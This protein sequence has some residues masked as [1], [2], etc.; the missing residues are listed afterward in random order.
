MICERNL[1]RKILI[2][3]GNFC[4]KGAQAMLFITVD[5]LRKRYPNIDIL[6]QTCEDLNLANFRFES[7]RMI[8][9]T[10]E[11]VCGGWKTPFIVVTRFFK[12]VLKYFMGRKEDLF[13]SFIEIKKIK[14]IDC[15]IDISG[16]AIG[17]KWSYNQNLEYIKRLNMAKKLEIPFFFMPQSIGQLG[18]SN[19][20]DKKKSKMKHNMSKA[21]NYASVIYA[22][23]SFSK[24]NLEKIGVVHNVVQM[25]DMVLL[26]KSVNWENIFVNVPDVNL[27]ILKTDNNIAIVPNTQIVN[28]YGIETALGMYTNVMNYLVELNYSVYIMSHS[29]E[30]LEVCKELYTKN[31]NSSIYLIENILDCRE[32]EAFISQFDLLVASRYHAL[33]HA[34]KEE[35]P[36]IAISWDEKYKEMMSWLGQEDCVFDMDKLGDIDNSIKSRIKDVLEN[37]IGRKKEI[38]K[39]LEIIQRENCFGFLDDLQF[40]ER[41]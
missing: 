34:L 13:S 15:I 30:D 38:R 18:F 27:P 40:P 36:C 19:L 3:G 26:H 31:H 39:W 12:D 35:I 22:R 37:L 2:T 16:Y 29:D 14:N 11:M 10:V 24:C 28:R 1:E 20:N 5:E 4:N 33:I 6:F 17:D 8:S 41:N 25:K 21:L 9:D 23:E 32:Y 7:V